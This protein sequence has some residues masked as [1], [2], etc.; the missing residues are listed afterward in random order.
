MLHSSSGFLKSL[1]SPE[2]VTASPFDFQCVAARNVRKAVAETAGQ[3]LHQSP[4]LLLFKESKISSK[5]VLSL[6]QA[7]SK[8]VF[9]RDV[10]CQ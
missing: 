6:E 5:L 9:Q 1:S 8:G 3:M 7:Y 2:A 10:V 4:A